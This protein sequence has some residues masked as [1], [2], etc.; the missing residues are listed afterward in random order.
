[1]RQAAPREAMP[2]L[3]AIAPDGLDLL[4]LRQLVRVSGDAERVFACQR[5]LEGL[6]RP[7][8]YRIVRHGAGGQICAAGTLAL[9]EAQGLLRQAY[10]ERVRFGGV[11]IHSYI[12][13]GTGTRMEPV[14]FLRVDAPRVHGSALLQVF[15]EA[16]IAAPDVDCRKD[17]MVFRVEVLLARMPQLERAVEALT[18]GVAHSMSWLL[19]YRAMPGDQVRGAADGAGPACRR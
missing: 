6:A 11:T 14:M 18:D 8:R 10:G 17:R 4:P 2:Q 16:G 12:D 7:A 13:A 19:G 3:S 9:E 5:L 1:M 15:R